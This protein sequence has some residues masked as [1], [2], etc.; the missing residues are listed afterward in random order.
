MQPRPSYLDQ[1]I[2]LIPCTIF[3]I[4]FI[5]QGYEQEVQ[6]FKAI[7][8]ALTVLSIIGWGIRHEDYLQKHREKN[9][10]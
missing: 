7:G 9:D 3:A 6:Y 8:W 10:G 5:T 4:F 2:V 1:L